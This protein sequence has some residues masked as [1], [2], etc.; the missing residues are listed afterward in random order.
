MPTVSNPVPLIYT[1]E[2]ATEYPC[3]QTPGE[4]T[5]LTSH[6]GGIQLGSSD[7]PSQH[8]EQ[9]VRSPTAAEPSWETCWYYAISVKQD[10]GGVKTVVKGREALVIAKAIIEQQGFNRDDVE[11]N[12][13]GDG[14]LFYWH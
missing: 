6:L 11:R 13:G 2:R 12:S 4:K 10:A 1:D 5:A 7:N 8:C 9:P 14:S 3:G